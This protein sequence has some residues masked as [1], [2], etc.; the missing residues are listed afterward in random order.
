MGS[1]RHRPGLEC[2]CTRK[3][4]FSEDIERDFL[5]LCQLLT[6]DE[7]SLILMQN[8]AAEFIATEHENEQAMMEQKATALA[9]C[10]RKLI[11]A[12]HLFEDGDVDRN[13]YLR[14]KTKIEQEVGYWQNY[15]TETEKMNAQLAM[16]VDA[17][18]KIGVLWADSADEDRRGLAHT[19]FDEIVYDLDTQKIVSF[20]LK[21]W[22][23]Q[24]LTLRGTLY[25]GGNDGYGYAPDRT[26]TCAS[27]SGGLRSIH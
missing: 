14:R 25:S 13:E 16:C 3:Q 26:R 21:V 23:D 12:R 22:A 9:K 27:A 15:T 8:L 6:L 7:Q 18:T 5:R 24:F 11:A 1:Y 2:G 20:R 10:E 17:V 4:V 19:L